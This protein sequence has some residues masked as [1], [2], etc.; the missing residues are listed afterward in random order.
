MGVWAVEIFEIEFRGVGY[1][2]EKGVEFSLQL[3]LGKCIWETLQ[4]KLL[5]IKFS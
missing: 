2:L 4:R 5:V 3:D 1:A